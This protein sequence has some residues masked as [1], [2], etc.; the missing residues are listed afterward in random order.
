MKQFRP[1]FNELYKGEWDY[2]EYMGVG[3]SFCG[4]P[5]DYKLFLDILM[6]V[7]CNP[8]SSRRILEILEKNETKYVTVMARLDFND[9]AKQLLE[10]G[11]SMQIV[12]PFDYAD[13]E[14]IDNNSRVDMA[15]LNVLRG[16]ETPLNLDEKLHVIFEQRLTDAQT[17]FSERPHN[18]GPY[19]R[20]F[21]RTY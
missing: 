9:I 18:F 7:S 14:F 20:N 12:P 3:L 1:K 6:S 16:D 8:V 21:K 2:P 5:N 13:P 11:V 17:S 15:V 4:I 10:V 19:D